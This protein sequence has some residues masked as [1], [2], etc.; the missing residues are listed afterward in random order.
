[1][2]VAPFEII[3]G[4]ADAY[5]AVVGTA[6]PAVNAAPPAAFEWLG[7]TDGGVTVTHTQNIENLMVDQIPNPVK[8]IRTE[9]GLTV[10]F[11]LAEITLER[12][13]RVLNDIALV[14]T[15]AAVGVAGTK[16][17]QLQRGVDVVYVA[18]LVRGPS[19]YMDANAQ[20]ELLK[21]AQTADPEISFVRD[22]KSVL[23][24]EWTAYA[25]LAQPEGQQFG[26]LRAQNAAPL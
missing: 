16:H 10:S 23:A 14:T 15:A 9:E 24:T 11:N 12:Y 21:V 8:A 7:R 26:I 6:F 20:F 25:D 17:F 3:A 22:D 19:P 5:V 18:M 13:R 1:M 4:P 2:A